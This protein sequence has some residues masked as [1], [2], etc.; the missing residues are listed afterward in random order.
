MNT[1]SQNEGLAGRGLNTAMG[2]GAPAATLG[3]GLMGLD[4]ISMGVRAGMGAGS[5]GGMGAGLAV[6]AG[7]AGIG[8]AGMGALSYMGNQMMSGAQQTQQFNQGMRGGYSFANPH[9][10]HGRGFSEG[11]IRQIGGNI[12][13][14]AG[15]Q[16]GEASAVL[17]RSSSSVPASTN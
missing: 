4:P 8:F 7:V 1:G 14:M 17:G 9:A 13:G 6:G 15:G 16:I 3:L 5:V 10:D 12:R 2:I 11:D